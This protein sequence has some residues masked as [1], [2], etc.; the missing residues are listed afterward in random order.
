MQAT[1]L[2]ALGKFV[3]F[4][5]GEVVAPNDAFGLFNSLREGGHI[6]VVPFN[7]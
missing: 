3:R 6:T 5:G 1:P 4:V 7:L 2:G